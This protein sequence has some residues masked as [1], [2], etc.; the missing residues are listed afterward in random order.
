MISTCW[1][2][3]CASTTVRLMA[4]MWPSAGV[5]VSKNH[6]YPCGLIT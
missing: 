1:N 6:L 5:V 4:C 2:L 3:V